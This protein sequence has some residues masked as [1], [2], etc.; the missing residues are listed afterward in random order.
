MIRINIH[1][2]KY[3]WTYVNWTNYSRHYVLYYYK[4][5]SGVKHL[6]D[7]TVLHLDPYARVSS[8]NCSGY[9]QTTYIDIITV[10]SLKIVVI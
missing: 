7:S 10:L 9:R 8:N 6:F 1:H 3:V 5:N 2:L 4:T